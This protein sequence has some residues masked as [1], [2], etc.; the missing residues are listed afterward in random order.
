MPFHLFVGAG[1]TKIDY[2]KNGTLIRTSL[3]KD[4]VNVNRVLD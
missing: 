4:L 3:L 1:S 2:R